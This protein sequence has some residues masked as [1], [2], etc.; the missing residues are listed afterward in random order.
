MYNSIT[1]S[2]APIVLFV[3]NRLE[4]TKKTIEA[5]KEIMELKTVYYIFIPMVPKRVRQAQWRQCGII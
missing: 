3:Y 2:Y 4:H 1:V 5:L